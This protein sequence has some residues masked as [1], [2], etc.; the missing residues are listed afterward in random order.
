[1]SVWTK[2][3][4][5]KCTMPAWRNV[6]GQIESGRVQGAMKERFL[7]RG[8]EACALLTMRIQR[9]GMKRAITDDLQAWLEK[10]AGRSK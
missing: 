7:Q 10:L 6:I 4:N 2:L 9:T 5:T 3:R 8:A 1:M